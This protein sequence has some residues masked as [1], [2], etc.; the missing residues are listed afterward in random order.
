EADKCL[1][2]ALADSLRDASPEALLRAA[3]NNCITKQAT[4][5]GTARQTGRR[6]ALLSARETYVR[7]SEPHP[8][9]NANGDPRKHGADDFR[10]GIAAGARSRPRAEH[11]R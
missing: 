11:G 10:H 1:L 9:A 7:Q 3:A 6:A 2:S 5:K 4:R 8:L